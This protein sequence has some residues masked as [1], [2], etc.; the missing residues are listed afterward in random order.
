VR[1]HTLIS[2]PREAQTSVGEVE[3]LYE[4]VN[5]EGVAAMTQRSVLLLKQRPQAL[6]N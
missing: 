6:R 4:V 5:Q 2:R 3:F 1:R